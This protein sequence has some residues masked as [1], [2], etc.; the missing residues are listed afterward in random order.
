[1]NSSR[2][3]YW[4]HNTRW[5]SALHFYRNREWSAWMSK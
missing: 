4:I 3:F 2:I 1:M 5:S